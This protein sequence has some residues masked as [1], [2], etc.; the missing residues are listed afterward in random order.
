MRQYLCK[1]SECGNSRNIAFDVPFP[2]YGEIFIRFCKLCDKET[3]Q[4]RVL[5]KKAQSE[6]KRKTTEEELKKSIECACNDYGFKCRFLY[7]SVIITTPLSDWS[8]DYHESKITLRHE[9]TIKINFK[10]NKYAK[11]H[12]QFRNR[13]MKPLEVID[14]IAS[15]DEWRANHLGK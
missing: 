6:I 4:T 1:C 11:M 9:S 15:H 2:E 5:T 13:K 14:Y 10:T 8:F 3:A 7:Q 12:V